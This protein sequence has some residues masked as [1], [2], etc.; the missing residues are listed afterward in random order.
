[1]LAGVRCAHVEPPSGGPADTTPPAVA[2][3][4]PPPGAV[5]VPADARVIL[6]FTEWI[7]RGATRGAAM[8]S[9]PYAGRARVEVD[10]DRLIV[11]PPAGQT[12]RP[13][14]THV[15]SVLGTLKDLRGN[16][17]GGVFDLRFSTGPTLDSAG[18]EGRLTLEGRRGPLLTALYHVNGREGVVEKANP[19]DTGFTAA[20]APEPWR[21]LPA[22]LAGADSAGRFRLDGAVEGEYGVFAF[23]DVNG[24]FAFDLGLEA[25]GV[26]EPAL[27][28]RPRA[29]AQALRLAPLDTL[30]L[31]VTE[32]AFVADS[33]G[34]ED[35]PAG[36]LH[37]KFG[38]PPH[39]ARAAEAAR[40]AVLP[41]SGEPVAVTG[42]GWHP[43]LGLWILDTPPLRA[44][45][46]HRLILRARPD[47]P[48]RH[49]A[50]ESDTSA[51]FD[52]TAKID[53]GA[54]QT[55]SLTPLR[56]AGG[57]TGL[58]T[59][60][61][62]PGVGTRQAFLSS[63]PLTP[64]RWEKL[65][66]RLEARVRAPR[67]TTPRARTHRLQ[68]LGPTSFAV[69]WNDPLRP[70]DA[71]ELR[72]MP[73]PVAGTDSAAAPRVLYAG[74]V[75]DT[76]GGARLKLAAPAGRADG[77][78]WAVSAGAS[79]TP[80]LHP[81]K[82]VGDSL[83]SAPLPTGRYVIHGFLDRDRDGV[84][85]PGA[86]RPWIPQEPYEILPDTLTVEK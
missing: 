40:Y 83:E 17:M 49:G 55:W 24:N 66:A 33:G 81:L 36:A 5:G 15:V 77:V 1:M 42:A 63:L 31:R 59:T 29:A 57:P 32:A 54:V 16:G 3:V 67:D 28:L 41:D 80:V 13:N 27:A 34:T 43:A 82:R 73:A 23:E 74:A 35:A 20:A 85:N 26:G 61:A 70:G 18:F 9:P 86:I 78:F 10:G 25:A 76:A 6:Q 64:A 7:D 37:V 22:Y 44:G 58:P 51:A 84:W 72:L 68:R 45:V 12:L 2:A 56:E 65:A 4:Y 79:A 38:R 53:T 47:F 46:R 71:L 14:T 50:D 60:A 30:P 11:R 21:E 39:P 19:R 8:I 75:P 52:V 48:G 62:T 69:Q